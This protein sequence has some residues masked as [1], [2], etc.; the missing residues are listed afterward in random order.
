MMTESVKYVTVIDPVFEV[1]LSGTADANLWR[2]YLKQEELEIQNSQDVVNIIISAVDSKYLGIPFQEFSI[3]V[4]VSENRYLLAHAYNS[5]GWFALA[6]RALFQ[7]PYYKGD[8][9][10]TAN[11]LRLSHGKSTCFEAHL[12]EQ[13]PAINHATERDE[14]LVHLPKRLRRNTLHPH[15]FCALLEGETDT[16]A[17]EEVSI[18]IEATAADS[19]LQLLNDSHLHI[20]EWRTRVSARHSKSKTYTSTAKISEVRVPIFDGKRDN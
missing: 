6:E 18:S 7:T 20:C 13:S 9:N 15:Y 1:T 4:E 5:I 11:H 19:V 8:V 16:F 12:A 3:S 2:E 10:V 14:L 17:G